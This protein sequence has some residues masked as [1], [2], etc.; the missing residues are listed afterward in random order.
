MIE[1]LEEKPIYFNRIF[2]LLSLVLIAKKQVKSEQL[3]NTLILEL[4]SYNITGFKKCFLDIPNKTIIMNRK[5]NIYLD[6]C[7]TLKKID[8]Y[9][10]F[11]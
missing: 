6:N 10:T 4:N 1:I 3:F 8:E 9:Y 11:I 2:E 5:L 7:P